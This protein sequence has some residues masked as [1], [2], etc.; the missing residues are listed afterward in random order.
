MAARKHPVD[1]AC[2]KDGRPGSGAAVL[3]DRVWPRGQRKDDAPWDEWLTAVAPFDRA[4]Q[5]VQPRAGTNMANSFA[6]TVRS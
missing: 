5:V 3:V 4:P 2:V 1:I 6:G